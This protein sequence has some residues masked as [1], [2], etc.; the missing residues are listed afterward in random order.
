MST[1][2]RK[3]EGGKNAIEPVENFVEKWK[4]PAYQGRRAVENPV[5]NVDNT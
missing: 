3:R 4:T 1:V 5:E 2:P